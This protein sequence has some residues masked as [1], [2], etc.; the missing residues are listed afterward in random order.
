MSMLFKSWMFS[1]TFPNFL[2]A[3]YQ[4]PVL[5]LLHS[6]HEEIRDPKSQEQIAGTLLLL[7]MVLAKLNEVIDIRMPWLQ[8]PGFNGVNPIQPLHNK[9][10]YETVVLYHLAILKLC[11]C[12]FSTHGKLFKVDRNIQVKA[13]W[14]RIP[15]VCLRPGPHTW[16]SRWSSAAWAPGRCCGRW[17]RGCRSRWRGRWRWPL[18]C[19]QP[20]EMAEMLRI[21]MSYFITF[22]HCFWKRQIELLASKTG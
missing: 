6:L 20:L 19:H 1:W 21:A 17:C 14:Q 16:P 5:V 7:A 8:I 13:A 18:R 12:W 3:W 4:R 2:T 9:S 22:Y 15:Y 11:G 10:S